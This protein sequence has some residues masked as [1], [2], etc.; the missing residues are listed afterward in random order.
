MSDMWLP[1]SQAGWLQ[2]KARE[3]SRPLKSNPEAFTRSPRQGAGAEAGRVLSGQLT[4]VCFLVRRLPQGLYL[5]GLRGG[6]PTGLDL[7]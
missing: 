4:Q 5:E 6:E 7:T 2:C 1:G 3:Q